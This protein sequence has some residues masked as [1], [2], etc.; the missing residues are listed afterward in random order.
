MS[1]LDLL[2]SLR[3]PVAWYRERK[4]ILA[5]RE[6]NIEE[7]EKFM[8]EPPGKII[9]EPEPYLPEPKKEALEI[10]IPEEEFS[11]AEKEE[12]LIKQVIWVERDRIGR[13]IYKVVK[14][15]PIET[16]DAQINSE[17]STQYLTG[18]NYVISE[19]AKDIQVIR[20]SNAEEEGRTYLTSLE[21]GESTSQY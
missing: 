2:K 6:R 16:P 12:G 20:E 1:L 15:F 9:E 21:K 4:R 5:E 10:E 14:Y 3:H 19:G 11:E 18:G 7:Y 8:H 13:R 17:L